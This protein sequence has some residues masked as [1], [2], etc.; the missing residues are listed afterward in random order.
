MRGVESPEKRR[1]MRD[2]L[3][4]SNGAIV[5]FCFFDQRSSLI[6]LQMLTQ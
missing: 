4:N 3:E 1:K 2:R 5:L 6:S